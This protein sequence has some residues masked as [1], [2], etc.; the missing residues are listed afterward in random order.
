MVS[1]KLGA[2]HIGDGLYVVRLII[3]RYAFRSYVAVLIGSVGQTSCS[4]SSPSG[5]AN[6]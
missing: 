2:I 1:D 3:S 6:G 4:G 5:E